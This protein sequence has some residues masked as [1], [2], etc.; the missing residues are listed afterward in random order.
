MKKFVLYFNHFET[1]HLGK[2]VFLVPYYIGKRY[3][4]DVTII[5]PESRTNINMPNI[6][7][8][9][10]LQKVKCYGNKDNF[11]HRDL[12]LL[13][14]FIFHLKGIKKI[15]LL[16][17]FHLSLFTILMILIY[18]KVNK[19]GKTYLKLDIN[20]ESVLKE[21]KPTI[22]LKRYLKRIIFKTFS[23]SIDTVSCET[24]EAYNQIK[25]SNSIIYSF[26]DK[27]KLMP[28]GFD[29]D[30]LNDYNI[31]IKEFKEK[32]NIIIT[33]GRLG[34]YQKNTELLLQSIENIDLK[35]WKV[36]LL[37]TITDEFKPYIEKFFA[38][39]PDKRDNVIFTGPIYDKHLLWDYYNK[40]KVFVL[41]SRFEGCAIVYPEARCFKNYIL[42]TKVGGALEYVSENKYGKI[43]PLSDEK[44]FNSELNN[45]INNNKNIDVYNNSSDISSIS[46]NNMVKILSIDYND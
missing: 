16:M 31:K 43:I 5:Y 35:N 32:D 26:K 27:L 2:D 15:D 34:T 14:H 25:K 40:A 10:K 4:Y 13:L 20:Y 3:G 39:N 24:M 9:V 19:T 45:I 22:F 46:W 36:Y 21:D 42:T 11:S 33:V 6:Y 37:G 18:K 7:R 28:N 44:E 17:R 8:G 29:D 41:T 38:N 23:N 30:L 1:E 12:S